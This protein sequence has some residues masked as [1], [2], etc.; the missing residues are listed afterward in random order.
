MMI[1]FK[2][3][4]LGSKGLIYIKKIISQEGIFGE[5]ILKCCDFDKGNVSTHLPEGMS[6][7]I[8]EDFKHGGKLPRI[9]KGQIIFKQEDG[10]QIKM[11]PKSNLDEFFSSII[12]SFVQNDKSK[13]C[14]FEDILAKSSDPCI[15]EMKTPYWTYNDRVFHFFPGEKKRDLSAMDVLNSA[16]NSYLVWGA[17]TSLNEQDD[18]VMGKRDLEEDDLIK[19]AK[20]VEKIIVSAYDGESYLIWE[21]I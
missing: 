7:S 12:E 19:F 20:G 3:Y 15:K 5:H 13:I 1:I 14:I 10:G 17:I 18:L 9:P 16:K 2:K 11:E 21:K 6:L 4:D 8:L